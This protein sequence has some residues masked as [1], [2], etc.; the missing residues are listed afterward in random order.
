M[1]SACPPPMPLPGGRRAE[2]DGVQRA[3]RHHGLDQ[4]GGGHRTRELGHPV[5]RGVE[6]ADLAGAESAQ[7]H[8]RVEVA[9]RDGARGA[10]HHG[11]REAVGERDG[12]QTRLILADAGG[13]DGA[14]ADEDE[15]EGTDELSGIG[16]EIQIAT[17]ATL[18]R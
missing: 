6:E 15:R 13:G 11:D 12:D 9:P 4:E 5:P 14:D 16:A 7:G 10:G 8:S 18:Q 3:A 1:S 17:I 2:V